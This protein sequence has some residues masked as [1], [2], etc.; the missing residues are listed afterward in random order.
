[1][2]RHT[3]LQLYGDAPGSAPDRLL[4]SLS[5]DFADSI[6]PGDGYV[7]GREFFTEGS[8]VVQDISDD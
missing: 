8:D 6:E 3:F 1:M 2:P 4:D 7:G 5:P